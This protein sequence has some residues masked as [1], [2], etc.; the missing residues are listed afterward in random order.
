MLHERLENYDEAIADFTA[1]AEKERPTAMIKEALE[2]LPKMRDEKNEKMKGEMMGRYR[3]VFR[4]FLSFPLLKSVTAT[5]WKSYFQCDADSILLIDWLSIT[6][7]SHCFTNIFR[8]FVDKLKDLGNL[9]LKPFG[10]STD[11]FKM[12]PQA[13]GGYSMKFEPT[14]KK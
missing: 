6:S 5:H 12:E 11:N 8:F 4:L 3:V 7:S 1:Y 10:L 2:R 9:V 14:K 13:S